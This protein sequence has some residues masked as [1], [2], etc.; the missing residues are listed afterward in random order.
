MDEARTALGPLELIDG[1]WV[2]GDTGRSGGAAWVEFRPEGLYARGRDG[3]EE[4]LPW[5]RIMLG[6]RL[7]LGGTSPSKGG[8]LTVLGWL[9]GLP[10]PFRGRGGGY[11]LMTVRHPY[12][13][14]AVFFDRHPRR[15]SLT[16]LALL[17]ELLSQT[18][19]EGEAAR[20]ADGDWLGRVVA[21]LSQR[22]LW[23]PGGFPRV[24][25]D[26]RQAEEPA[27]A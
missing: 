3:G 5:S 11:L 7:T 20:L 23:A 14:R 4:V 9:G 18:V 26:A 10:G 15:Y 2:L 27:G 21:R 8:P 6:V 24:V 17:Q 22:R 1:R 13:D 19:Q 25:R 16:E 12:E